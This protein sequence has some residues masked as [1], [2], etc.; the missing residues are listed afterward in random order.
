MA[1]PRDALVHT[2]HRDDGAR[3]SELPIGAVLRA[4]PPDGLGTAK[5]LACEVELDHLSPIIE[6]HVG[7]SCVLLRTR[8][9]DQNVDPPECLD[10]LIEERCHVGFLRDIATNN[11]CPTAAALDLAP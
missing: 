3:G 1:C 2:A 7:Y 4:K 10:S 8:V 9:G 5:E 6:G 11:N